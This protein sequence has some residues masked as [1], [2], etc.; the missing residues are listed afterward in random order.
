LFLFDIHCIE[1][2]F[3]R[4]QNKKYHTLKT[5][6]KSNRKITETGKI[7]ARNTHI[8]LDQSLSW[9]GI[10]TSIKSFEVELIVYGHKCSFSVK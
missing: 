5:V 9:Y 1:F 4:I 3:H 10:G 7:D 6:P 2:I 8:L